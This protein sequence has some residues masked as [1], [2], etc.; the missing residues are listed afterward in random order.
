MSTTGL[1][2]VVVGILVGLLGPLVARDD[3]AMLNMFRQILGRRPAGE[4]AVRAFKW[5]RLV[6]AGVLVLVG[7]GFLLLG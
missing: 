3:V 5:F 2:L 6:V 4:R 1:G 7:I